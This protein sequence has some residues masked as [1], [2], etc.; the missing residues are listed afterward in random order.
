MRK[1]LINDCF[2][3]FEQ[4]IE[5]LK[6]P[7]LR[8]DSL[9]KL[10]QIE[11]SNLSDI[12]LIKGAQLGLNEMFEE[13]NKVDKSFEI[14]MAIEILSHYLKSNSFNL[15]AAPILGSDKEIVESFE[16]INKKI[17]DLVGKYDRESAIFQE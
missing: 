12:N 3:E 8:A 15:L 7:T 2:E 5:H 16:T 1:I 9:L 11:Q 10:F 17:E 6:T 4:K 13:M 14:R